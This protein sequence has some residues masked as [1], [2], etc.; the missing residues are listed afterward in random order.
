MAGQ[1]D[2]DAMPKLC[3][4][5]VDGHGVIRHLEFSYAEAKQLAEDL[6]TAGRPEVWP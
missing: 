3:T 1:F 5:Y 6:R 2:V 4:D